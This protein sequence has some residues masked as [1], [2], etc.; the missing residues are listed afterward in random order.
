MDPTVGSV[1]RLDAVER[2]E[3][4]NG[5]RERGREKENGCTLNHTMSDI[6]CAFV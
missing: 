6:M 1:R 5:E 3:V 2:E 4:G